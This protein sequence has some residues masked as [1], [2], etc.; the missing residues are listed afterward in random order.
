MARKTIGLGVVGPVATDAKAHAQ[1]PDLHNPVHPAHISVTL[2]AIDT[3]KYMHRMVEIHEIGQFVYP[4]PFDWFVLHEV[5]FHYSNRF[6][7]RRDSRMAMHATLDGRYAC[8]RCSHGLGM[9]DETAYF[10]ITSVNAM[11]E[12]NG[13]AGA[14][15]SRIE[16]D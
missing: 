6:E 2:T 12:R 16:A 10:F 4:Y 15:R 7:S 9:T 13:L 14:D 1:L 3:A 11:T 8:R 5:G